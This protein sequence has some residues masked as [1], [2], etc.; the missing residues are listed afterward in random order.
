MHSSHKKPFKQRKGLIFL[1]SLLSTLL[2]GFLIGVLV[3]KVTEFSQQSSPAK[4][5]FQLADQG[6]SGNSFQKQVPP[7]QT[8]ARVAETCDRIQSSV[9]TIVI[10]VVS[11]GM[12]GQGLG[13]GVIFKEEDNHYYI[14]TNA[15]VVAD[16]Q[17]IYLFTSEGDMVEMQLIGSDEESDLAV[18]SLD[19][20]KLTPAVASSL[21]IAELGDSDQLRSG[22]IAIAI[23][24][25]RSLAYQNSVTVGVVSYPKRELTL[26]TTPSTY[27]QTDAAINP[28]NSGGG[29]FDEEGRLIGINS[30][31]LALGEVEGI[32]FSIP[33]NHVREVITNLME[34]GFVQHLCLGGIDQSSFLPESLASLY[35]VPSGLIVYHVRTGS[36][37]ETQGLRSGDI[38]TE[39]DGTPLTSLE[40]LNKILLSHE[41][42]DT[43]TVTVIRSRNTADPLTLPLV[44][45]SA[46]ADE[47]GSGKFWGDT[48]TFK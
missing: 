18:V 21:T 5:S 36:S 7:I 13:S 2:S 1:I 15:H 20:S 9:V 12:A 34:N 41:E 43:V 29:L 35:H 46:D 37:G 28:G 6:Y 19:K 39:V 31:K 40:D 4:G 8:D 3:F 22:Q 17:T 32:A 48:P 30:N 38:I 33:I 25:P 14:I 26:S 23:G 24:S 10:D 16:A 47:Q 44:L 27:I 45:E 42:G 11:D